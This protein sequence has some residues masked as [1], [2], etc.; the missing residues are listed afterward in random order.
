MLLMSD[1][2]AVQLSGER[3]QSVEIEGGGADASH[4]AG[5][6]LDAAIGIWIPKCCTTDEQ[7]IFP[8]CMKPRHP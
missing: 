6:M 7:N 4:R 3:E 5:P 8:P 1:F 2:V